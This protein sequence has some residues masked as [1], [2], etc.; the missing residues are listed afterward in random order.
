M[1]YIL[2][3]K[4]VLAD[5]ERQNV[6]YVLLRNYEFLHSKADAGFDLDVVI[7]KNDFVQA[8]EILLR[9]GFVK[10]PQQF[11]LQH[12]GFGKYFVQ[13]KIKFGFDIQ[14]G[15][16]HWN[17]MAY[18]SA[19]KVLERRVKRDGLYVLS[20][21]D[22]FIMYICHSVLGKRRFK[23]KYKQELLRLARQELDYK[24]IHEN[25]SRIFNS[26]MAKIMITKVQEERFL[27]LER[28]SLRYAAY[29]VLRKPRNIFVFTTLFFR[30]LRWL[31]LG[32]SYPLISFIGPDGS[33]KSTAA[34]HLVTVLQQNRRKALLVY[35][36]RGKSNILPIKKI[37]GQYKKTEHKQGKTKQIMMY[38]AAAPI[39]T[40]DLLIRYF[41]TVFPQRKRK[42][43]MVTDR[44]CSDILLM[45]HVPLWFKRILL[46]L[47]PTPTLTFYL[48][49]EAQVLYG[50]RKQQS[51]EEL[52]RQMK[53][54]DYLS[55][56]FKAVSIQTTS[57]EKDA[58]V[59]EE[60]VF[61]YFM[62]HR[63]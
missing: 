9:H 60:K 32:R 38:S 29:F 57:V 8:A 54:F 61:T 6:P 21:E 26:S 12:K 10:Y 52:E 63:Y 15:G 23:E 24:Y 13:E 33:G 1:S 5:F 16:I 19:E 39:Y 3:I 40:L 14:V 43:I 56:K 22:A 45:Q 30:W 36:G 48:H 27:Y 25:L 20:D 47:F 35:M 4:K 44:Y 28:K 50:R 41:I 42:K 59:I 37:A 51:V 34:E 7:G 11:S 46:S 62:K 58:A 17:D 2:E 31:R 55:K 53:L 18:L 49:N